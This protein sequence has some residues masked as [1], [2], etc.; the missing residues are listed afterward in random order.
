MPIIDV[1]STQIQLREEECSSIGEIIPKLQTIFNKNKYIIKAYSSDGNEIKFDGDRNIL[2]L[3]IPEED[4]LQFKVRPIE[5]STKS[6]IQDIS[7]LLDSLL[8]KTS[9]MSSQIES[10]ENT[11]QIYIANIVA[12]IDTC[13]LYTSPSPRD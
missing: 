3:P 9:V 1:N 2:N 13:L 11:S 8:N 7:S 6:L 5:D 10:A 12:A 4:V